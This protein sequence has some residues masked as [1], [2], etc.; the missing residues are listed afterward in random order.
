MNITESEETHTQ[1]QVSA[2]IV[3]LISLFIPCAILKLK[4]LI[5]ERMGYE[6]EREDP[7]IIGFDMC[8]AACLL[9]CLLIPSL[10]CASVFGTGTWYLC[11][12]SVE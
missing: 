3:S 5:E 9:C 11:R 4:L 8:I 12:Y 7:E 10:V 1:C 2:G 6:Q